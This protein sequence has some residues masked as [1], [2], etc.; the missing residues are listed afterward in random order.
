MAK[1]ASYYWDASVFLAWIKDE[2]RGT[3]EDAGLN[4]AAGD[5]T[6]KRVVLVSSV[7]ILCEVLAGELDEEKTAMLNQLFLRPNI[8]LYEVT[9]DVAA[10]AGKIREACRQAR[11]KCP[12]TPDAI[13]LATAA[14][15]G[16]SEIHSFDPH[17][18]DLNARLPQC[19]AQICKPRSPQGVLGF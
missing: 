18:L 12:P 11:L 4:A 5:I 2:K 9:R 16:A 6:A 15:V 10:R 13:H 1:R 3:V 14:L 8:V 7:V 19:P 17:F